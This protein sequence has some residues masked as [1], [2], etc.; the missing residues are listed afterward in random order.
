MRS[1]P[2]LNSVV[3]PGSAIAWILPYRG[4]QGAR[5]EPEPAAQPAFGLSHLGDYGSVHNGVQ[6]S[7][8][9]LEHARE[10]K[11]KEGSRA[12]ASRAARSFLERT[13]IGGKK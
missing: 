12:G 1:Q 5:S 8:Y 7:S 6:H 9:S 11:G 13:S 2:T 4:P 3:Q 10:A